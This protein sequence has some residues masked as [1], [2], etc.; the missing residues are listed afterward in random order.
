[1]FSKSLAQTIEQSYEHA[2]DLYNQEDY[3][4]AIKNLRRVIFFDDSTYIMSYKILGDCYKHLKQKDKALYYYRLAQSICNNDSISKEIKFKIVSVHLNYDEA[5]YALINLFAID[6]E[7]NKYFKQQKNFYTSLTYFL[8]HNYDDSEKH[9]RNIFDTVGTKLSEQIDSLYIAAEK[10]ESFNVYLPVFLSIIP[11]MG[12]LYLHEYKAAINSFI[13]SS[14]FIGLYYVAISN[15]TFLDAVLAVLPWFHRY[16]TGG[17]LQAKSL[18][19]KNKNN[20]HTLIYNAL[21]DLYINNITKS[22]K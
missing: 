17:L 10:N 7:N 3:E 18:A 2:I 1:L 20:M 12:Q 14:A 5:N 13:L 4:A 16:Y 9:Y 22:L 8:L 19:V 15:L 11:G 21:I 6:V